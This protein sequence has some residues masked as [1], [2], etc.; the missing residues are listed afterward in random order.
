MSA[1][2]NESKRPLI[3]GNYAGVYNPATGSWERAPVAQPGWRTSKDG[4]AVGWM[5]PATAVHVP[6]HPRSGIGAGS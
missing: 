1:R 5:D 2:V 6:P 3:G 4:T